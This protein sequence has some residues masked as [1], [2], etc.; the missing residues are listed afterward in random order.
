MSEMN[1]QAVLTIGP[2]RR[3]VAVPA[4][5]AEVQMRLR[6]VSPSAASFENAYECLRVRYKAL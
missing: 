1:D 3:L 5:E 6:A 4:A 2:R